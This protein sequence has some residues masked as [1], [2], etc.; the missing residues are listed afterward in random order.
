MNKRVLYVVTVVGLIFTLSV[1]HTTS[2]YAASSTKNLDQQIANA[3]KKKADSQKKAKEAQSR[4]AQVKS[5]KQLTLKEI[6][7]LNN[8]LKVTYEKLEQLNV[9][10]EK[11]EVELANQEKQ[12]DEAEA[13]VEKRD[14]LLKSR[15]RLMYTN[16]TVSYLDVL[17][18]A[19][20][21]SDF[22]T[23]LDSLQMVFT[24]D[25]EILDSNKKDRDLIA[26]KKQE[27][28][29]SLAE[30]QKLYESTTD[31][32]NDLQQKEQA[33]EVRVAQLA[34]EEHV[35][36]KI[37]AEEEENVIAFAREESK[38][39]AEK[40]KAAGGGTNKYSGGKFA[41]PLAKQ[42]KVT[43]EYGSRT[44]P[45]TGKQG[46]FHKGIDFGAPSGSDI[47]AADDGIVILA[48]SYSGY[49]NCVIINHGKD[50]NGKEIWTLYG[51]IR[52]GGIKV[53]KGAKV[54]RGQKIAEVGSTG[55]STGPHLHFEVR[56]DEKV[57]NA[58]SYLK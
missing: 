38:L 48:G 12:L 5:D 26:A 29:I 32:R 4:I 28:M 55:Q 31:I 47:L 46:E 34:N 8:Q 11:T 44:N 18:S 49:G 22:L 27:V 14:G 52:H 40:A 57:V 56:V 50:K 19:T 30:A 51:H 7:D 43:S 9:K 20:S 3:K 36:E 23:R 2:S 39:Q 37:T 16:G 10:L 15:L 45:V 17:F 21:F 33:K 58:G 42:A 35:L 54:K 25:Q 53:S 41:Y 1:T 6:D 24:Q 13:R